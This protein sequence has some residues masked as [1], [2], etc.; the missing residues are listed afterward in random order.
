MNHPLAW[1]PVAIPA[2][3]TST[4]EDDAAAAAPPIPPPTA[5]RFA[6]ERL[7]GGRV[8]EAT[9]RVPARRGAAVGLGPVTGAAPGTTR[10]SRG[11]DRDHDRNNRH[12]SSDS[13]HGSSASR[14]RL[15]VG[16]SSSTE[17]DEEGE[18]DEAL[19]GEACFEVGVKRG[20]LL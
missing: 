6:G 14:P 5:R 1:D 4:S 8:T 19:A 15:V 11:R 12:R 18:D 10:S 9:A 7:R 17:D 13:S 2:P 16:R 20:V 3:S